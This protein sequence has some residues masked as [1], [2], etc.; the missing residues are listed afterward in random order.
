MNLQINMQRHVVHAQL[1]VPLDGVT[2]LF[3]PSGAGKT[4]ILRAIAGLE[5]LERGTIVCNGTIWNSDSRVIVPARR[6]NVGYL[7]QDHALF[8][9][10][11]VRANVGYGLPRMKR[12]DRESRITHALELTKVLDVQDRRI[13]EL[14]GGEAQR[15]A[16]ARTL[17]H[18]PALLLLDEPL[19]A[20][21]SPTRSLMRADIR[22]LLTDEGIPAIVV[23]HDRT[24][25]LALGDRIVVIVEGEVRQIGTPAEV[26]DRPVDPMVAGVLGMETA[27]SGYVV[28]SE[29]GVLSVDVG[30]AIVRS[31]GDA[32]VTGTPVLVCIRAEDV[33]LGAGDAEMRTSQ[34]NQLPGVIRAIEAEGPLMRVDMDCGFGLTAYITRPALEDLG[35]QPDSLAIAMFKSQSVHVIP[36]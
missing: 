19:S 27:T 2:V 29:N 23:T 32:L 17:A 6:R 25:A 16:L 1:D 36:R 7:F 8:P 20:L 33:A 4:T 24:E 21:D 3:G 12:A 13:I 9:H 18:R 15:V 22:H 14:S 35:L 10:L 5:A 11:S 30:G 28:G 26:F 34:R 31:S